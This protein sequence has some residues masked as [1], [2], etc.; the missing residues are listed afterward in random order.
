MWKNTVELD[1]SQMKLR[2][3]CIAYWIPQATRHG[4]SIFNNKKFGNLYRGIIDFKK[5]YQ[6]RTNKYGMRRVIGYRFHSTLARWANHFSS[7][8]MYTGLVMLGRQKYTQQ[9]H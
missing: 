5:V 6:P 8:S 3:M 2:C 9:K 4:V 7:Y 1:R